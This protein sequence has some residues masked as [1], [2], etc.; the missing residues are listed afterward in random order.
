KKKIIRRNKKIMGESISQRP[1]EINKRESFGHW[2]LD[3]VIGV[4]VNISLYKKW[5]II[6]YKKYTK[7]HSKNC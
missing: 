7:M 1:E 6:L 5:N 2:E 3:T 4:K